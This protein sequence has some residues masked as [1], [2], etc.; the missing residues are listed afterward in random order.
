MEIDK[1]LR[2]A[3]PVERVWALLLDPVAMGTCVPGMKSIEVIGDDEYLAVMHVKISF[4]SAN[5][6]LRTTIVEKRPPHYLRSQGTG[7]DTAVASSL[8][9][10]SEVFLTELPDGATEL[11]IKL[12][13]DVLG[14]LGT[15]GLSVMKTKAD[16]MW[17]EFGKNIELR[18]A[19]PEAPVAADAPIATGGLAAAI[20]PAGGIQ[21]TQPGDVNTTA[22]Q[23]VTTTPGLP[24]PATSP[25]WFKRVL[26]ALLNEPSGQHIRVELQ[27]GDTHLTLQWPLAD[28]DRCLAWLTAAVP[29]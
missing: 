2:V 15:F 29:K 22:L 5:F 27:R 23:P 6:K 16:R 13:A 9:Q 28:A 4:I 3:A 11:R 12:V 18:L 19:P 17:D 7:E 10:T 26:G 20:M 1:T 14:R 24:A 8:K 25:G 21:T